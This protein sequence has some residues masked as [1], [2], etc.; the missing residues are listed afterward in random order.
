M[1][2]SDVG[3]ADALLRAGRA[4]LS[5]AMQA[6]VVALERGQ[7]DLLPMRVGLR[8]AAA[9]AAETALRVA[10]M[11][12]SMAG[13]AAMLETGPLP[14]Q[15]RDLRAAVQHVAMAPH[16]FITAGRLAMGLE[17]GTTRV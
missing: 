4:L 14:W 2:Q 16:N 8:Q 11:L 13:T 6:L 1:I 3:R 15:L 9:H 12:E 5:E 7:S 10:A 17:A